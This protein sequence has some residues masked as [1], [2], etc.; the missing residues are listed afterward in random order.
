MPDP[1]V[2]REMHELRARLDAM[3][4]TQRCTVDTGDISEADSE[5]EAG[6]EGE[7][8]TVEDA[9][10]ERL[11]RAVARIGAREKMEIP[12]YEGNLDV[13]ELLDWI[14]ALDKYFDYED[15]EEDKKVKHVVTRLK[16]HAT[17]W[18]DELQADRRCKGKQKIKSW[19]RMVAKMKAKFIPKDYQITLFRRMQNLRQKLM[20]V[21]EY[22]EE[23]YK[24]NIRAGHRESDD[25]KVARY[26]NGLRYDIQDEMSMMIIRNVEDAYQMA[27]KAEEKLSQKQGQRGRGRSQARGKAIAQ[28]RTQKSKEEGKKPQTQT[29]RG[30]SSQRGQYADRNTFPRTRGR[31]RGRGGEVKCFVCGKN[32]HKSYECPDRKKEGG[33]THIAEAQ[34]WNVEAEDAEGGRSLMMRKVLLMPEKEAENP[35][36]RNRLFRTACKTKDRVCK[37]IVDNGSTNN[38][39]S[40]EMVEKLELE[41]IV[42]PSPYR[43]SWLQKGHQVNVTKQC[44]V[45]FKIGGYKDEILCDVIPM[46]VCHLLLGRPWQYDR[47]VIHDGRKNTY[48]LEKNGRTHMLLPIKDKE[49]KT[50]T[51]NT[52]LLMSGKELLNEVKKK[53]D[54]QFIV[55]RKPRIVL[56]STRV[57]DLP[58]EIQKL[59]EGFADIVVDELPCSLPPIRSISHHIDLIPGASLPNK[60]AYR[61]TLQENEEVK[62][63]VQD[64]MDK[65]L[66]RESLS[67]CVVPTVLS[68]KKDGGWRMCT[69]SREINK[70]T[71]RYRFPLPRMDDL[72]DCLSGAK[73]FSKIDLKSGYHQIR[74][75]EGDEWK[76]TFKMNEGLYEWL[77]MPFGLTNAPST[78]MRL[79]NEVLKDFIG[80]F[81]IVY[82]DDILI[83][84]KTEAEHLKHLATVMRRLQQEKL[85]INMKKSTFM[86][87]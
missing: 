41:T 52:V 50:E 77:V 70:I 23:F 26:M 65:G 36:Q 13:E 66:V 83:F 43:V 4:T 20:T 35:T 6:H 22:T 33:E 10:D 81:V 74:M 62:R 78:F 73:F 61:L 30:G 9:A 11:F 54:T 44:L 63:Q 59:L 49:V 25:E 24:I 45:E 15:V 69:D 17:L 29:E 58:E 51:S 1:T 8:V 5:N 68:P 38:L 80:K 56:T 46:D 18:W 85:L 2:E 14:R 28:D 3:E 53:E 75:R 12:M 42:H 67:P 19:D 21:K 31:G 79:M 71:I 57:D 37:V 72:M 40:I 86:R 27:L 39:I 76:T 55:V 82:L 7:E 34:G 48:T 87:T 32:G 64:L 16:G 47:N 84:S 60:A